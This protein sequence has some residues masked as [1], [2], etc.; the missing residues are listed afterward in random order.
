MGNTK[1][2][3][4]TCKGCK[5][6]VHAKRVLKHFGI[7]KSCKIKY[8]DDYNTMRENARKKTYTRYDKE[9]AGRINSNKRAHNKKKLR[10]R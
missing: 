5:K 6:E 10:R 2:D 4:A 1:I 9:N 7:S 8:G 3:M